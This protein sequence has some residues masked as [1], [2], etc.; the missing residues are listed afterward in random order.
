M[1]GF[2]F[3][4]NVSL[5]C[6]WW[7]PGAH[8]VFFLS[9]SLL[10]LCLFSSTL[11]PHFNAMFGIQDMVQ[12]YKWGSVAHHFRSRCF[13]R[14]NSAFANV[15][16]KTH[17]FSANRACYIRVPVYKLESLLRVTSVTTSRGTTCPGRYRVNSCTVKLAPEQTRP[18]FH[19][20]K[21]V[22]RF[23][24]CEGNMV[25]LFSRLFSPFS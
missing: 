22:K 3:C 17:I 2:L 1:A 24:F 13:W 11:E 18:Y 19:A 10:R 16:A 25:T 6:Q 4:K 7:S 5:I 9:Q 20:S 23:F 12:R 14:Q 8:T 21:L 15:S